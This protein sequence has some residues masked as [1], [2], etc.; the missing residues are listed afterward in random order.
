MLKNLTTFCCKD[1]KCHCEIHVPFTKNCPATLFIKRHPCCW[2]VNP[3]CR[4]RFPVRSVRLAKRTPN[5]ILASCRLSLLEAKHEYQ[6]RNL[7]A[8]ATWK[9]NFPLEEIC[10]WFPEYE[11]NRINTAQVGFSQDSYLFN[12]D[13]IPRSFLAR[14]IAFFHA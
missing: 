2:Q 14:S 4:F 5:H 10:V 12:S 7:V 9:I 6:Y 3:V 13:W 8:H 11:D 1:R